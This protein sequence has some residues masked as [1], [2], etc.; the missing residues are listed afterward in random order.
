MES[1]SR[2]NEWNERL[3]EY[4]AS[5]CPEPATRQFAGLQLCGD[6]FQDTIDDVD[7]EDQVQR[8]RYFG[9]TTEDTCPNEPF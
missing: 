7:L 9:V 2:W 3:C 4:P 5:D 8:T 1:E 6:H